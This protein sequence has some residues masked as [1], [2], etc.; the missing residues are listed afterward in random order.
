MSE[1][2]GFVNA[3]PPP[4]GKKEGK[5]KRLGSFNLKQWPPLLLTRPLFGDVTGSSGNKECGGRN[6]FLEKRHGSRRERDV[7]VRFQKRQLCF[8]LGPPIGLSVCVMRQNE[9]KKQNKTGTSPILKKSYLSYRTAEY[10]GPKKH[11]PITDVAVHYVAT[12]T[13]V[14]F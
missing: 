6:H 12:Y 8:V 5:E 2:A 13:H 10:T 9:R 7:W 4:R 14:A 3:F 11:T 1:A